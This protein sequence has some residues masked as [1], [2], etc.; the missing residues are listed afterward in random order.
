MTVLRVLFVWAMTHVSAHACPSFDAAEK[1][2]RARDYR[3][4]ADG[5]RQALM[6]GC[7]P[8][9]A[10]VRARM[11]LALRRAGQLEA[12]ADALVAARKAAVRAGDR[13]WFHVAGRYLGRTRLLEGAAP[14]ALPL[15]GAADAYHAAVG[16]DSDRV[17]V[18][19]ELAGVLREHGDLDGAVDRYI[20][21]VDAAKRLG[22]PNLVRPS[23]IGLAAIA[24]ELG[25]FAWAL[26]TA[27]EA[28][29]TCT[30]AG[31]TPC[32]LQVRA[33]QVPLMVK[34]GRAAAAAVL[35][36]EILDSLPADGPMT[37]Q[38]RLAIAH[39]HLDSGAPALALR[40]L[41][42]ALERAEPHLNA[43]LA[44]ISYARSSVLLGLGRV[45]EA[46]GAL[47]VGRTQSHGDGR[48]GRAEQLAGRI[49]SARGRTDEAIGHFR[50]FVS[51]LETT[52]PKG[53]TGRR[54][55][56]DER[57]AHQ[58]TLV[59]LLIAEGRLAEAASWSGRVKARAFTEHLTR[60]RARHLA[61]SDDR[62]YV[63]VLR[64]IAREDER[65][66]A[67]ADLETIGSLLPKTLA[68]LDW[69]VT[70]DRILIT[71]IHR[72]RAVQAVSM[73]SRT[74]LTAQVDAFVD[75][76]EQGGDVGPPGE[77]L[78]KRLLVPIREQLTGPDRPEVVV[79][80]PHGALH[81]L[82]WA[83]LPVDGEPLVEWAAL[84]RAPSLEGALAMVGG[85]AAPAATRALVVADP[86]GTLPGARA[87]AREIVHALSHVT[88]LQGPD[89]T[90]ERTMRAAGRG[91]GVLHFAVHAGRS[92]SGSAHLQLAPD[93]G[94]GRMDA[95]AVARIAAGSD[96]LALFACRSGSARYDGADEADSIARLAVGA[97]VRTAIS[98]TTW[99]DDASAMRL[100]EL[101]YG[102][103]SAGLSPARALAASQR[104]LRREGVV[105]EGRGRG[106]RPASAPLGHP[107]HW[108]P[109]QLFGAP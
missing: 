98:T 74:A 58:E 63:D 79:L 76:I 33:Y 75:A 31:D 13:H 48:R 1:S 50:R 82:P 68:V 47:R 57:V 36:T 46:E 19:L 54:F 108:A 85:P 87:E 69:Y 72:G 70:A 20:A 25:D 7:G 94:D 61:A 51:R 41:D 102:H 53:P 96:L 24:G 23:L 59:S 66:P 80:V 86:D 103:Y 14:L 100:A 32:L 91:F 27:A 104:T 55:F 42:L 22:D 73:T 106:V 29:A 9:E 34:A 37:R 39:A 97:G 83:A 18:A 28:A 56:H 44:E 10:Q 84:S 92:E 62:R 8:S 88:V 16:P 45:D 64:T 49:A 15:L 71:W 101:F 30:D 107:L 89:A 105:S 109:Y 3:A 93:G 5:H 65:S 81:G 99:V 38:V 52:R 60:A 90:V 77:W 2:Y 67:P 4:A 6:L 40:E 78:A 21:A 35:G 95:A 43:L 26:A 17:A 11:G 12:A